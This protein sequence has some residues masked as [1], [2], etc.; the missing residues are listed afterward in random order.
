[1]ILIV[2]GTGVLGRTV[3][4]L[5]VQRGEGVRALA[6]SPGSATKLRALG[7][8]VADG[9]LTDAASLQRACVGVDAVLSA[10]HGM[11]GR[12]RFRSELVDDAGQ[13]ALIDAA[14]SAGVRHV[15][16]L[17]VLGASPDHPIDF[18]RAK[19]RVEQH[20]RES[21]LSFTVLRPGAFMEWH[22]HKFLGE[23]LIAKG[24]TVILG[25]GTTPVNF[26]A[27][28]DVAQ[29]AVCALTDLRAAGRVLEIGGPENVTKNAVAARYLALSGR[30]GKV[31]HVPPAALRV[32]A[33]LIGPVH[34]GVARVMRVAAAEGEF[35]QT[36]DFARRPVEFGVEGTTLDAFIR[37]ALP[38]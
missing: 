2:G 31:K 7:A 21:G 25:A 17:S 28:R 29:Y 35:D 16:Y 23:P 11:L 30:T 1:M 22:A 33:T 4:P 3:I 14:R 38:T 20:L 32:L 9:D 13:R 26:I 37:A 15:A 10:A 19:S 5:L 24:K 6:R 18:W 34:A 8:E 27:T 12:G 36:F